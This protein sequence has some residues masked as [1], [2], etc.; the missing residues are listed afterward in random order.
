MSHRQ[1]H[2][3]GPLNASGIRTSAA[4]RGK[5]PEGR[6]DYRHF[7]HRDRTHAYSCGEEKKYSLAPS[8]CSVDFSMTVHEAPLQWDVSRPGQCPIQNG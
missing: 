7:N 5:V 2:I 6:I 8:V 4:G 1:Q 3:L